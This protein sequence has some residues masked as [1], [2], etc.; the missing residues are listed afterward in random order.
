LD[1]LKLSV[2]MSREGGAVIDVADHRGTISQETATGAV[3]DPAAE[4]VSTDG[5]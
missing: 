4:G 3:D 2:N 1:L 5:R